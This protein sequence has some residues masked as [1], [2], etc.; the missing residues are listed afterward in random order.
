MERSGLDSAAPNMPDSIM[1]GH[2]F[3]HRYL[4][5]AFVPRASDVL[6]HDPHELSLPGHRV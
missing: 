6:V 2:Q 5:F 1:L 4:T 3:R